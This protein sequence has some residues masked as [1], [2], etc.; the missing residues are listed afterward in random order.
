MS[1]DEEPTTTNRRRL[2][3]SSDTGGQLPPSITLSNKRKKMESDEAEDEKDDPTKTIVQND[4]EVCPICLEEW[5]NSGQHRLVATECGHLFGRMFVYFFVVDCFIENNEF[6]RFSCI[7]KWLRTSPKCPQC[8][9]TVKKRDLRRIYCRAL[10][11]LDTSERDNA[12]KERDLEKKARKK[13]AYEKAELQLAYDLL[14]EQIKR[15][16]NENERLLK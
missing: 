10:N 11:V 7:E 4:A 2:S 8:Q 5:T 13:L 6:V 1:V 9:A 16:Q 14:K 15:L 3:S 12:I